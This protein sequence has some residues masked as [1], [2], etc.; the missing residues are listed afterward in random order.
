[1][2]VGVLAA[3]LP[4]TLLTVLILT[5][6]A[7]HVG[8]PAPPAGCNDLIATRAAPRGGY[9]LIEIADLRGRA[10]VA[11][12]AP[13]FRD[14]VSGRSSISP[15]YLDGDKVRWVFASPVLAPSGLPADHAA[16]MV[17]DLLALAR[18]ETDPEAV[19]R[20][21]VDAAQLE[22]A[23]CTLGDGPGAWAPVAIPA[24]DLTSVVANLVDNASTT[25]AA[26]TGCCGCGPPPPCST[27]WRSP[28]RTARRGVLPGHR[29]A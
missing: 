6:R 14:A 24:S 19:L 5:A 26:P 3:S 21:V 25:A 22:R 7:A 23:E 9:D 11:P 15:V 16:K 10:I 4:I 27:R 18:S 2:V 13:W 12:E 29:P 28:S 17:D 8:K 1:M 20:S